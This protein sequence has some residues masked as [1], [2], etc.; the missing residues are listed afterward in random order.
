M[1]DL[2]SKNLEQVSSGLLHQVQQ[3]LNIELVVHLFFCFVA[4]VLSKFLAKKLEKYLN[5]FIENHHFKAFYRKIFKI[6]ASI[7]LEI[8]GVC[9]FAIYVVIVNSISLPHKAPSVMLSFF[10]AWMVINF[11]SSL[12]GKSIFV[13]MTKI[14]VLTILIFSILGILDN[15]MSFLDSIKIGLNDAKISVLS[16][17]KGLILFL[18]FLWLA[19][20]LSK[21]SERAIARSSELTPSLK[22]LTSKIVKISLFVIAILAGLN[23]IG[24]DLTVFTI[25]GG[26][27]GVGVGFG[28]QK[29]I[30]NFISGI[31]LLSDRSIKPGDVIAINDTYGW[32]N[33][34]SAR[35]V[36]VIT[37]DGKEHL[38][39]NELLI[40]EKVENWS[41]SNNDVRMRV[42]FGVSYKSDVNKVIDLAFQA[43]KATPRILKTPEPQCF[44]TG[45]GDSSVDFE[46]RAWINDPINGMTNIKSDLLLNLWNIF[47]QNNI[48][49]PFP[50]RDLHI[51]SGLEKLK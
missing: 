18:I 7:T 43:I 13:K 16:I 46:I 11:T 51:K 23:A 39:P 26:A 9:V 17:T 5:N 28:L 21:E 37:R 20:I 38:I 8:V 10:F 40:T 32:V 45:F 3:Y 48:E 47:K 50:Q 35:Y 33:S 15:I 30:S 27:V 2:I 12:L 14:F 4:L 22:V 42:P 24:L 25:F 41:F 36:S 6:L 44:L 19:V 29:I 1:E 49:I 31:I 34:L